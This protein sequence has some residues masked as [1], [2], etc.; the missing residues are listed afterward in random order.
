MGN[1]KRRRV[2]P[3][4]AARGFDF[5][6]GLGHGFWF[7]HIADVPEVGIL[8]GQLEHARTLASHQQRRPFS[9]RTARYDVALPCLI[10]LSNKID[11][12]FL[13][14]WTQD[15]QG[16][17]EAVH[18]MIEGQPE[19]LVLRLVPARADPQDQASTAHLVE[20]RR[21][22]RQ[23]GRMAEGIAQHQRADLHALGR[24]S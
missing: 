1:A 5:G 4:L 10:I 17:F 13:Q 11:M 20:G 19:R 14:Q 21:H 9:S 7:A 24:F 22:F 12:P 8:C 2:P 18:A 3:D 6:E 16:F 23:D 15:L